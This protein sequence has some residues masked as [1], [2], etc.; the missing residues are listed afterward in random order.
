MVGEQFSSDEPYYA[1]ERL[2]ALLVARSDDTLFFEAFCDLVD[3]MAQT[4][5]PLLQDILIVSVLERIAEDARVAARL[6][7]HIGSAG[8]DMLEAVER[9]LF[10][11]IP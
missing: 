5:D 4:G 7:Q 3:E 6:K 2:A 8:R 1:Y 9:D 11:R 10:G